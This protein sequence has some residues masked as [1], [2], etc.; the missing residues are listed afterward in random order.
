MW[1]F[2]SLVDICM[3]LEDGKYLIVKDPNKPVIRY[4][5]CSMSSHLG[6]LWTD[7]LAVP[8]Y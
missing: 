4:T 2:Q 1:W 7:W 6:E 5:N 8:G 3:K